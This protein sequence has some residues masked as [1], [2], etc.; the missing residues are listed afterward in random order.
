MD[1]LINIAN[2]CNS[3]LVKYG[4]KLTHCNAIHI[5]DEDVIEFRIK[6]Y[7]AGKVL[8]TFQYHIENF[9]F[10][11]TDTE[12]LVNRV[13]IDSINTEIEKRIIYHNYANV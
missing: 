4:E 8:K 3:M 12:V 11:I 9:N 13:T 7:A 6:Y 10:V 1:E 5:K 2:Y